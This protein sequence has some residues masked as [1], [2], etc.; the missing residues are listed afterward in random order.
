MFYHWRWQKRKH[1]KNKPKHDCKASPHHHYTPQPA[2]LDVIAFFLRKTKVT[3]NIQ[4]VHPSSSFVQRLFFFNKFNKFLSLPHVLLLLCP[5]AWV[6]VIFWKS[7]L[8]CF[9]FCRFNPSQLLLCSFYS[10]VCDFLFLKSVE[11]GVKWSV[12]IKEIQ[13]IIHF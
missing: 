7:F 6:L 13:M 2:S 8:E 1:W 3:H 4:K 12:A 9:F 10:S 11:W 5:C